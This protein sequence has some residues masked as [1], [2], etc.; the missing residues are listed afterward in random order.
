M[1]VLKFGIKYVNLAE[2]LCY[3][4][5]SVFIQG[6]LLL[7][8]RK[9]CSTEYSLSAVCIIATLGYLNLIM[10]FKL[11]KFICPLGHHIIHLCVG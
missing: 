9:T 8:N 6:C 4:A 1:T 7:G 5:D 2:H 11:R 3:R 10:L